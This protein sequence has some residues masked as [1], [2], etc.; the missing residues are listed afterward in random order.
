MFD[1]DKGI[2]VTR[3]CQMDLVIP[4]R[5]KPGLFV[6][7]PGVGHYSETWQKCLDVHVY[8]EVM[9]VNSDF[10]ILDDM[11]WARVVVPLKNAVTGRG[12]IVFLDPNGQEKTLLLTQP[13]HDEQVVSLPMEGLWDPDTR[14]TGP[15]Q[16]L[17]K[18][19]YPSLTET[20]KDLFEQAMAKFEPDAKRQHT[21]LF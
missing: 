1:K 18:I 7:L 17:L 11:L 12:A 3:P 4:P 19:Q 8:M 6:V 10:K 9:Q 5:I 14:L 21:K 20:E 15:L 13:V 16:C 2:F